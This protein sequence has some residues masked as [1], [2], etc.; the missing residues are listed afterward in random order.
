[1]DYIKKG[2][3]GSVC[4]IIFFTLTNTDF[5]KWSEEEVQNIPDAKRD[6]LT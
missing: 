2:T 4:Y 6:Q 3:L 5:K 1:M